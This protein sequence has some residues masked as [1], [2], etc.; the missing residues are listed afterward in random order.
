MRDQLTGV[1]SPQEWADLVQAAAAWAGAPGHG[2]WAALI[3]I[4]H[5]K[6]FN[7]HNGHIAGDR[8]LVTLAT[9]LL[10]LDGDTRVTPVRTGGQEF[11]LICSHDGNA[12]VGSGRLTC[13]RILQWARDSLTPHQQEHCGQPDC[14]GPTRLTLSIALE[15][16]A[17]GEDAAALKARLETILLEAKRAGRDRV[18]TG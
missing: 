3:D 2:A 4:D 5:F 10:S 1:R 16:I 14:V 8:V 11:A 15:R 6:R 13:E 9:F 17:P 12:D 7:M 18:A